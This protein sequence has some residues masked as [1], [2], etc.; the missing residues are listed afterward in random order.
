[1]DSD[2]HE[3]AILYADAYINAYSDSDYNPDCDSYIN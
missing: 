1:M 2:P 3:Y